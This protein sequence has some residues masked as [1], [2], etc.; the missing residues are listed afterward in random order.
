MISLKYLRFNLFLSPGRGRGG[1]EV[2]NVDVNI[3]R[4][5]VKTN[6]MDFFRP[7]V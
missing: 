7:V 2:C 6:F 4:N 3:K 1:A 5:V